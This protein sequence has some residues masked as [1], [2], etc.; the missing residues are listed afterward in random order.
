MKKLWIGLKI[1]LVCIMWFIA[2][3]AHSFVFATATK[4][5]IGKEDIRLYDGVST[6]FTRKTSTGGTTTYNKI[7][8]LGAIDILQVYGDGSTKTNVAI[9]EAVSQIGIIRKATIYLS[10]GDWIFANGV[11]VT[12]PSN[13][14]LIIPNGA[15]IDGISGGGT[16]TLAINGLLI[17][18]EYQIFGDNITVTGSSLIKFAYPEWWETNTTP[19]TTDMR[20]AINSAIDFL[21]TNGGKALLGPTTYMVQNIN[22]DGPGI[23]MKSNVTLQGVGPVSIIKGY[24]TDLMQTVI[25][26]PASTP[27]EN[28]IFKD[29]TID[30]THD[31]VAHGLL[32]GGIT[33]LLIDGVYV[34][35][36]ANPLVSSGAIGISPFDSYLQYIS[37]NVRVV[38][39]TFDKTDNFGVEVGYARGVV[40]SNNTFT[41][42]FRECIGF[43]SDDDYTTR[44]VE[45][46]IADGNTIY[47]T[48]DSNNAGGTKGPAIYVGATSGDDNWVKNI[49]ISNNTIQ[50]S[51][52]NGSYLGG[53][54]IAGATTA[55]AENILIQGNSIYN[56]AGRGIYIGALTYNQKKITIKNNIIVDSGAD[57]AIEVTSATYCTV[58]D[59]TIWGSSHTYLVQESGTSNY[60]FIGDNQGDV[61][62]SGLYDIVGANTIGDVFPAQYGSDGLDS[63][64]KR[65]GKVMHETIISLAD[66]ATHAFS[67]RGGGNNRSIYIIT[68]PLDESTHGIF[69]VNGTSAIS[70]L[71]QSGTTIRVG[72]TNP[73]IDGAINIWPSTA[74]IISIKNRLGVTRDFT[75]WSLSAG[76]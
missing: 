60:N 3:S 72:T 13:I 71:A 12:I 5:L 16:E 19:G 15:K 21:T 41:N 25:N 76:N 52:A 9:A 28:I 50:G 49:I 18:K 53:I 63:T 47:L 64:Q 55:Y 34:V 75:L 20:T 7:D 68:T 46:A 54:G 59:N 6:T 56:V 65:G 10:P 24:S 39:C 61:G 26:T 14:I 70:V 36:S 31:K 27:Q 74:N 45:N 62:T 35:G 48:E 2:I 40:V 66:D 17:D 73:D 67:S 37:T 51:E 30:R 4:G 43:E 8:L 1:F 58:K 23:T 32:T 29:F 57:T 22:N 44:F 38:N 69:T 42:C 33:N 11:T